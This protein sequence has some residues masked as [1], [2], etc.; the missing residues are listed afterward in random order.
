MA[1]KHPHLAAVCFSYLM[2]C[3]RG[4][5]SCYQSKLADCLPPYCLSKQVARLNTC[6]MLSTVVTQWSNFLILSCISV[7]LYVNYLLSRYCTDDVI[8]DVLS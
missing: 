4:R 5:I 8:T 7:S 3:S 2:L 1:S 6:L